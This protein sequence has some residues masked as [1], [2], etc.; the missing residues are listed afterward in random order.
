MTVDL[1]TQPSEIL[2]NNEFKPIERKSLAVRVADELRNLVL[3]EKLNDFYIVS[4]KNRNCSFYN[5]E[6]I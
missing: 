3:L 2:D 4:A 5:I 6:L 1:T